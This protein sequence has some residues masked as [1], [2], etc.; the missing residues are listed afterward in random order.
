[1]KL[2]EFIFDKMGVPK[3][4]SYLDLSSFR[5]KLLAGNVSNVSTPGYKAQDIDFT[6]EYLKASGS[7]TQLAGVMTNARH[8]P[9]GAHQAKPP[10]VNRSGI[11]AGE[12]NSV[13]VDQEI[14]SMAQNELLFTISAQLLKRRFDG[15]RN[16]ITS[17]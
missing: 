3:F 12:I 9:T 5:H 7:S 2:T 10:D 8:L 15:L 13:N 17:E 4:G 11:E 14:A 16:A 1:M 6:K